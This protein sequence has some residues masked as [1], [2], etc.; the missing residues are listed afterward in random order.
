MAGYVVHAGCIAA[1]RRQPIPRPCDAWK[2]PQS[3]IPTCPRLSNARYLIADCY[4]K[5]AVA[6]E[7]KLSKSLTGNSRDNQTK[8]IQELFA[9]SLEQYKLVQDM[10]GKGSQQCRT[11]GGA[12][13][14]FAELHFCDRR[15][16]F[17]QGRLR[18]SH[19]SIFNG[20]ESLSELS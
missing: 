12:E 14:D 6:A 20:S 2:R 15:R 3:D 11:Y 8:Q 1:R 7:E 18:S 5:M 10:L 17:R 16:V 13:G 19:Q 9:K 4:Y